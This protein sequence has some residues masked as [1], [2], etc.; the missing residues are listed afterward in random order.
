[1]NATIRIVMRISNG[2]PDR[3]IHQFDGNESN[4]EVPLPDAICTVVV[5]VDCDWV[6]VNDI[7]VILAIAAKCEAVT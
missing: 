5:E 7:G 3:G 6:G 4:C 1:M 2:G